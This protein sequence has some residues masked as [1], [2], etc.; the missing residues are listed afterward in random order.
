MITK[1]AGNQGKLKLAPNQPMSFMNHTPARTKTTHQ[2]VG[3]PSLQL[4][5][6]SFFAI[7]IKNNSVQVY[8]N[9][10]E[11]LKNHFS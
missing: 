4:Q 3:N 8:L 10:S 11:K 1:I 9:F 5:H 6:I 2:K 7:L